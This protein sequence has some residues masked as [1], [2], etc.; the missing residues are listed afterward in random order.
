MSKQTGAALLALGALLLG[1]S[2]AARAEG[3]YAKVQPVLTAARTVLDEPLLLPDGS[4][5]KVTSMIVTIDP[6][7]ET[8]WHRHGVPTYIYVLAG[9]V[10]VDYGEQGTRAFGPGGSFMEAMGQWHRGTNRGREPVRILAVYL[11]SE[12]ARNVIPKE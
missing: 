7:E 4:P 1:A 3:P 11:G 2:P 8:A 9:E 5:L 12:T 6:G 10:T